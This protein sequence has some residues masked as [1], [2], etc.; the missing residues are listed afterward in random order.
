MGAER[1][2]IR[3]IYLT[4]RG[5]LLKQAHVAA[6]ASDLTADLHTAQPKHWILIAARYEGID[7]RIVDSY[8]LEEYSI[9][10]YVLMG[11]E[12]PALVMLEAVVR[13]LPEVLGSFGSTLEESFVGGL[14]EYPQYTRPF[15]FQGLEVPAVLRSGDHAAIA[16]WRRKQALGVTW[17]KRP[18]LWAVQSDQLTELDRLLLLE[19]KQE[20]LNKSNSIQ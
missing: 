3:L 5:Q 12:L 1:V 6:W 17:Q 14:L 2:A 7:E 18:D 11:G 4:P 8:A 20:Q 19:F 9:G 10:D 13:L 16:R 15:C